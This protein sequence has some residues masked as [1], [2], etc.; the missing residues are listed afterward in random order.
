[1]PN[2]LI[3]RS[4][5]EPQVFYGKIT[6]NG[7]VDDIQIKPMKFEKEENGK[8]I[9]SAEIELKTGGD[10]GYT[11]RVIPKNDMI[12]EPMNLDLIKWITEK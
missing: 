2:E 6:P 9:Y 4:S 12:L 11:F 10:Y 7:I 8:N 5:I 1:M 3:D